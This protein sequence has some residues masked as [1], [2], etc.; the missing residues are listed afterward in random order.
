LYD[1]ELEDLPAELRW[2][3]GMLRVEAV[4]SA[5]A[6]TVSRETLLRVVGRDCSID[7][8]IDD[9]VEEPRPALRARVRYRRLAASHPHPLRRHHSRLGGANRGR[10][11]GAVGLR[12]DGD[13]CNQ[14]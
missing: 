2:R 8:L 5:S 4:I 14:A 1:W 6:E 13:S 3:E 7:L 11:R 10:G 12:G 9:L